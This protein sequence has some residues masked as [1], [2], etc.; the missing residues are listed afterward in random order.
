MV[1]ASA[2]L[3]LFS[4]SPVFAQFYEIKG[5]EE[6]L[7]SLTCN[8]CSFRF[9]SS[10]S[11]RRRPGTVSGRIKLAGLR[12]QGSH[13]I[14]LFFVS[15]NEPG[16]RWRWLRGFRS[17]A[18][19]I[20]GRRLRVGEWKG[21]F[22]ERPSTSSWSLIRVEPGTE[23]PASAIVTG[24]CRRGSRILPRG[25]LNFAGKI[26]AFYNQIID[27]MDRHSLAVLGFCVWVI[28]PPRS[29]NKGFEMLWRYR[30]TEK[31]G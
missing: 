6:A 28:C 23:C 8:V 21:S 26:T 5:W 30:N 16:P 3:W 11:E 12:S 15:N 9:Y 4:K 2:S 22:R 19:I 31:Y 27:W 17:R 7:S 29:W 10:P 25:A 13:A 18:E 14:V 24:G 1:R 20:E